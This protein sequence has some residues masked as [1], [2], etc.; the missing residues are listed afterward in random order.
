MNKLT[1]IGLPGAPTTDNLDQ[2]G[3]PEFTFNL[4][5]TWT[6]GAFTLGYNLRW[7]DAQRTQ[8]KQTTDSTPNYAPAAQLR[9]SELWQHDV[10]LGLRVRGNSSFYLGVLNL[11]DQKPDPG[12]AINEPIS[13]VGRYFYAGVKAN[14]GGR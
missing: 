8:S 14:F 2:P 4:S 13:A 10:Q 12:N 6:I 11:T 9:Y 7:I 5:P 1:T 3:N